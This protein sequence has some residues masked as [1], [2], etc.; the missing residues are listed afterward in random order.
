MKLAYLKCFWDLYQTKAELTND[1][2]ANPSILF[3][4]ESGSGKSNGL[5]Y[6]IYTLLQEF[7]SADI[8]FLNYKD[9]NDFKFFK[10]HKRYFVGENCGQGLENFYNHYCKMRR[11]EGEDIE[12]IT[13]I[14]IDEYAAFYLMTAATD[15]KMADRYSRLISE[16]LMTGRSYKT[17]CWVATQRAD[18][19]YFANGSREQFQ[20]KVLLTRGRPSKE[21]LMMMGV[22]K[23]ELQLDSYKVGEG[24]AYIDGK[25]LF[26]IKY[27]KYSHLKIETEILRILSGG[28]HDAVGRM[29]ADGQCYLD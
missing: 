23:E 8:W 24:I 5:K 15:K 11:T 1:F 26:E 20:V 25:G 10:S 13:L 28:S 12:H 18:A 9:S 14:V 22:S 7:P 19:Q 29:R 16:I 21:S 4:G 27:P 6:N 3:V 2:L 17:A